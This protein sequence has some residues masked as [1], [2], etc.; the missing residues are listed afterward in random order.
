MKIEIMSF[1]ATAIAIMASFS[2]CAILVASIS[3]CAAIEYK[4][5][6]AQ[7]YKAE[8]PADWIVNEVTTNSIVGGG[9]YPTIAVGVNGVGIYQRIDSNSES[10]FKK[11]GSIK[12]SVI[13]FYETFQV[14][15][16]AT[17]NVTAAP[18]YK[19]YE[20]EYFKV[21]YPVDWIVYPDEKKCSYHFQ[22]PIPNQ[23]WGGNTNVTWNVGCYDAAEVD[24][25]LDGATVRIQVNKNYTGS[26]LNDGFVDKGL[27]HFLKTFKVK[28]YPTPV[29]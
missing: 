10:V 3:V 12:E 8:Y 19:V 29:L 27:I 1:I 21:E 15:K 5:L 23:S 2:A 26:F 20:N 22:V 18:E 6:D 13:H 24:L 9:I 7:Y 17:A 11:D 14:K 16:S 28:S 25:R 4:T